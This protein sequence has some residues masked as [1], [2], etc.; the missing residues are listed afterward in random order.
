MLG[1]RRKCSRC[2]RRRKVAAYWD[3]TGKGLCQECVNTPDVAFNYSLRSSGLSALR[4]YRNVF[5]G[6]GA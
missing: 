2:R 1:L 4:A 3:D 6:A 5:G